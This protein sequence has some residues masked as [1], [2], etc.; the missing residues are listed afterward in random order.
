MCGTFVEHVGR[1]R[2]ML[3]KRLINFKPA[4]DTGDAHS[5]ERRV[6]YSREVG[7]P[8]FERQQEVNREY[9]LVENTP[10]RI[11]KTIRTFLL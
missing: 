11:C 1:M 8:R 2:V 10:H 6:C 3:A 7:L 4:T 5:L 9:V